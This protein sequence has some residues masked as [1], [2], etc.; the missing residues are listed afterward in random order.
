MSLTET[1]ARFSFCKNHR[2]LIAFDTIAVTWLS[3]LRAE[4]I[5]TPVPLE[6]IGRC[7][8]ILS[9]PWWNAENY[10]G[11]LFCS[12]DDGWS[13]FSSIVIANSVDLFGFIALYF[14]PFTAIIFLVS[15]S[16]KHRLDFSQ[17]VCLLFPVFPSLEMTPHM[18]LR[19]LAERVR[20]LHDKWGRTIFV[21]S[22]ATFSGL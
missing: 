12:K 11:N 1:P 2:S 10:G 6:I 20:T 7:R 17:C 18:Q 9:L 13:P 16:V 14:R 3:H 4:L 8:T 21:Q 19:D 5:L 22:P 15:C